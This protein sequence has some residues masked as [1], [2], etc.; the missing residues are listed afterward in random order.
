MNLET[1]SFLF[2]NLKNNFCLLQL[3]NNFNIQFFR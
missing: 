3:E 2:F 1:N